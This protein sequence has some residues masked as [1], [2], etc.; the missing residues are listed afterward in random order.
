[1][2]LIAAWRY[3][4]A[5]VFDDGDRGLFYD[6]FAEAC[7]R[8]RWD[9]FARVLMENHYHA[10]FRTPEPNPVAGMP[11]FQ[12]QNAFTRRLNARRHL[13]GHLIFTGDVTAER[14]ETDCTKCSPKGGL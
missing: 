8:T 7:G 14:S 1:M 6:T 2:P 3:R 13:W 4:E 11:W 5:I 9:V 12:N 10:L